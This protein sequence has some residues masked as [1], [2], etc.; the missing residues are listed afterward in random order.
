MR[1]LPLDP[2]RGSVKM[3]VRGKD[4]KVKLPV[5]AQSGVLTVPSTLVSKR[6]DL[7]QFTPDMS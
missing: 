4:L 7:N 6:T 1:L 5:V 2:R 3:S